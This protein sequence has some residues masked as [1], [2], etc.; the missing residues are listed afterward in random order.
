VYGSSIKTKSQQVCRAGEFLVAEIDAK[1]GGFGIVPQEL[2]GA[3]VS[4]HYF[5]FEIDTTQLDPRFLGYYIRT[6]D[7]R[8]RV[9]AQGTTNYAAIRPG[10]VLG[11]DIPL[12]PLSEQERVVGRIEEVTTKLK[13]AEQLRALASTEVDLLPSSLHV[14]LAESRMVSLRECLEPHEIEAPVI[15]D[16]RY[17]QAGVRGFGGGLFRKAPILGSQTTYTF[18]HKLFEGALVLSQVKGWEGAVAVCPAGLADCFVSPEYRTFRCIPGMLDPRY[19]AAIVPT[20][21]FWKRLAQLTRGVG[22]R[23]ERIRPDLFLAL[24][25]PMPTLEKQLGALNVLER[26]SPLRKWQAEQPALMAALLPS[27]I[28]KAFR[29]E[30]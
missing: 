8:N 11:Y 13:E 4:S 3:V 21:W 18:F 22:A 27:V 30:L 17:P 26:F 2:G 7:F 1:E 10:D 19:L 24:R 14:E 16:G 23:R 25:L 9:A 5:L 29:G 20:A 15:P 12:P 28:E 6:P